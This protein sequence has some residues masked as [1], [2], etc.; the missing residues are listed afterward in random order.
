MS[1]PPKNTN[2]ADASSLSASPIDSVTQSQLDNQQRTIQLLV[3]EK[4]SLS[5]ALQK[6]ESESQQG[7]NTLNHTPPI[8]RN[9]Y[10]YL[11]ARDHTASLE[12]MQ[13]EIQQLTARV[14]SLQDELRDSA[15]ARAQLTS[16]EQ[17]HVNQARESVR[18]PVIWLVV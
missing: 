11:V 7:T 9:L 12:E 4:T 16:R 14:T 13:T 10:S 2:V 18:L 8:H 5:T 15:V 17:E 6:L 3:S 1:P